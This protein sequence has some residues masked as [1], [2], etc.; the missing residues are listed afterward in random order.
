MS[1]LAELLSEETPD[2]SEEISPDDPWYR[3]FPS[4]YFV[5]GQQAIRCIR[6]AMLAAEKEPAS[7][8]TILDFP[9]GYGRILRTLKAAFPDAEVTA[10]DMDQV[11]LDFCVNVLGAKRLLSKNDPREI[12]LEDKFDLIWCGSLLTHLDEDRWPHFLEFFASHLTENG[13]LVFTT[14]GRYVAERLRERVHPFKLD[15]SQVARLLTDYEKAGFGYVP[16]SET[17]IAGITVSLPSW[18]CT[19]LESMRGLGLVGYFEALWGAR[20]NWWAQDVVACVPAP[21]LK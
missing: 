19:H 2:V 11:G 16:L 7:I 18:V 12:E 13:L 6:L 17:A 8:R 21:V 4:N 1:T 5:A 3:D 10:S 20:R 15:E 9:C 14:H